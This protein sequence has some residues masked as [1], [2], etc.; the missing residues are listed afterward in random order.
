MSDE[1]AD[2]ISDLSKQVD[3]SNKPITDTRVV[4][5]INHLSVGVVSVDPDI[6]GVGIIGQVITQGVSSGRTSIVK[7]IVTDISSDSSKKLFETNTLQLNALQSE[8][9]IIGSQDES[10]KSTNRIICMPSDSR[11]MR[12]NRISRIDTPRVNKNI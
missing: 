8:T 7:N 2:K 5:G 4:K 3:A 11:N 9:L 1:H 10:M 6:I 12:G